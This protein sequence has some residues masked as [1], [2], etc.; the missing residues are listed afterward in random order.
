MPHN[1]RSFTQDRSVIEHRLTTG[2]L[3]RIVGF[4]RPYRGGSPSSSLLIVVDAIAGAATRSIYRA[5]IDQGIA[6]ERTD[7]V[8]ALSGLLAVLAVL[9]AIVGLAQ[10]W[11]SAR[12]GEGLIHDLR[13]QVFDH[14]QRMPIGFFTRAQTGAL[15][16]RLNSDVQG[17]QQAFTS[18]LSNVVG[19]VVA[20]TATLD[21]DVRAVV[22]DHAAVA[23]AAAAVRPARPLGRAT[24]RRHHPRAL[25]AQR[26]DGPDDDRAV[27]R[28]GRA[29]RQAVRRA[30]ARVAT[31]SPIG[32]GGCATSASRRPCTPGSS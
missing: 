7:L 13:T 1:L 9:S 10:R 15:V 17:A 24:A 18:T 3:R 6:Q 19:N 23:R 25:P 11:F 2:T 22:A 5:I 14:V 26:R 27:Q 16:S 32:P 12:I 4:A 30:R 29:A 28:V 8:V 21:R 20:V 31:R